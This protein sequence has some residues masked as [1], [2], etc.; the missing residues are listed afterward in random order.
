VACEEAVEQG[1]L[2]FTLRGPSGEQTNDG[3]IRRV[4]PDVTIVLELMEGLGLPP[5]ETMSPEEARAF[6]EAGAEQRPPGPEVGEIVDGTYPGA[7]GPLGYRLYRPA[8]EGPHP[9]TVYYHGGGWVLGSADSDDPFCR[10]LCVRSD[11]IIVSVDYRH[12]PEHRFPAPVDDALAA[13]Q[14]VSEHVESLGGR[15]GP[16]VVAGW[17]AG[18]NLATV[19]AQLARDAGGP[20]IAGQLL[21]TPVTDSDLHRY[22]S[23]EENAERY[24]LTRNLMEWFFDHYVDP[25]DRDD[26]RVAPLRAADLSN[27]PPATVITCEFDPL[28][29]EGV[30]Y[31]E[32]L[33]AAGNEVEHISGRGHTHTSL[34]MVDII[35]SSVPYREQM[36][37]ALR[38]FHQAAVPA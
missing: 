34:T 32:A 33:A 6:F 9:V 20:A 37:H 1:Y 26:L 2:G 10:D 29:D 27:L 4:Q 17:S 25:A 24:V 14:W 3:V 5:V 22:P 11:S 8:S 13:L 21:L 15:P 28:R 38:G 36:A 35:I 23:Y 7:A 19:V 31:A 30:A 16:V 12:A 18:A